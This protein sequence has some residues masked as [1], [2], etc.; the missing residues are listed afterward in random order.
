MKHAV[1][2]INNEL[3]SIANRVNQ[4]NDRISDSKDRNLEI[5]QREEGRN[6][7]VKKNETVLQLLPN[8]TRKSDVAWPAWLS[9]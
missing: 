5:M 9:S 4:I 3:L 8:S 2:N 1:K 6:V 7:S